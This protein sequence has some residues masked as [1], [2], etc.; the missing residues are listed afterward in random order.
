VHRYV[1]P[2]AFGLA[3][4]AVLA[5]ELLLWE[6]FGNAGAPLES[7]AG[8]LVTVIGVAGLAIL[9]F[10]AGQRKSRLGLVAIIAFPVA[11]A[12]APSVI[13]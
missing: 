7:L 11:Y 12:L 2:L 4:L 6:V 8:H 1:E 5:A 10:I 3:S 13:P 9:G